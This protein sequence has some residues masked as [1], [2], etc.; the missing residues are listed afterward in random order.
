MVVG[1]MGGVLSSQT[2]QLVLQGVLV[3]HGL[4]DGLAVQVVPGSSDD[5][6]VG[7]VLPQQLHG[8]QQLLLAHAV[9]TAEDDG[10]SMLHLVVE[11]LTKVLHVYLALGGIGHGDEGVQLDVGVV[12]TLDRTDD[13][14]QL[15]HAGGLDEDAVGLVLRQDLLQSLTE[16][17]HQAAA[18]AAGV[19]LGDLHAGILEETAVDANLAELVLNEDQLFALVGFLDQLLDEGGLTGSQETGKDINFG[20]DIPPDKK[21]VE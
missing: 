1:V 10:G 3:L 18:D 19:H 6:S 5:G 13:V 11:E 8:V 15:A 2:S 12:Q 16:V 9:G 4:Q 21:V 7:V 20:H 14:G 17:T